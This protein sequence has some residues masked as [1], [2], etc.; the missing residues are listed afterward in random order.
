MDRIT[1][2]VVR[3]HKANRN[4]TTIFRTDTWNQQIVTSWEIFNVETS[5]LIGKLASARAF[6]GKAKVANSFDAL[7]NERHPFQFAGRAILEQEAVTR[8]IVDEFPCAVPFVKIFFG[9]RFA[10]NEV[11]HFVKGEKIVAVVDRL[12]ADADSG[13]EV[14]KVI[15]SALN[16]N[17][18]R[19]EQVSVDVVR[20]NFFV[21]VEDDFLLV[22]G[23]GAESDDNA[24]NVS[25]L[26]GFAVPTKSSVSKINVNA[27][28]EQRTP[29][30]G[31]RIALADRIGRHERGV[32]IFTGRKVS[33]FLVPAGNVV[34][35]ASVL[36][37]VENGVEVGFL[38]GVH[39]T[40]PDEGR[41]ADDV[42]DAGRDVLPVDSQRI[43][44][45]NVGIAF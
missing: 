34:E 5:G 41:V 17:I 29:E 6:A 39:D 4:V 7:V 13:H 35:V 2:E 16:E 40:S 21:A 15:W 28:I 32:N 26:S 25:L 11:G 27:V 20:E 23:R 22:I 19:V 10:G 30:S 14:L 38:R 1:C 9:S 36:P 45:V 37:A 18:W 31:N 44:L 8:L 43:A 3:I 33:G 24:V 42:I 12:V